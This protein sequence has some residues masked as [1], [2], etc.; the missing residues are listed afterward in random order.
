MKVETPFTLPFDVLSMATGDF[1]GDGKPD[2]AVA[3]L[4]AP[5]NIDPYCEDAVGVVIFFGSHQEV[6]PTLEFAGCES[7]MGSD[8]LLAFDADLDGLDDLIIGDSVAL[9]YGLKHS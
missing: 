6:E 8:E 9:S 3:Q 2:L 5:G 4:K 1:N 7:A